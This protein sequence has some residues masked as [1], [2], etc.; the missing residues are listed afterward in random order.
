MTTE[1]E[2]HDAAYFEAV[3]AM[4]MKI[5]M[6][7]QGGKPLS[8]KEINEQINN[9]LKASIQSEGV[10]NLFDSKSVGEH[11]SLFDPQ[12]LEEISKIK[13]KNIAVEILKKLLAEQISLYKRTNIVKSEKF[14]EKIT[15][16]MNS[17][18][19]GLIT[20]EEVIKELL[21][22]AEEIANMHKEGQKLG[23]SEEELAF[24]MH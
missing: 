7:G 10:I 23:L 21:E 16:L 4:I 19:N 24:M 9:L 14:S 15:M 12:V 17:Y 3:R 11:F 5:T 20:N 8:L 2:R 13:E 18:Y 22:A 1:Q 6:G